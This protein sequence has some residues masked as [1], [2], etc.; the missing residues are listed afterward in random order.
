MEFPKSKK[1]YLINGFLTVRN[2]GEGKMNFSKRGVY[3]IITS[4]SVQWSGLSLCWSF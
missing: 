1:E 3:N 4:S 2:S